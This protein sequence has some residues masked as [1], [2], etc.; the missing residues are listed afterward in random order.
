[1]PCKHKTIFNT[2]ARIIIGQ[3]T[4]G[5]VEKASDSRREEDG[6]LLNA[7]LRRSNEEDEV[8]STSPL[9]SRAEVSLKS[10]EKLSIP[11]AIAP[12]ISGYHDRPYQII[13]AEEFVQSLRSQIKD[14]KISSLPL[15]GAVDQI[16]NNSQLLCQIQT[17]HRL[18]Q[19]ITIP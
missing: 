10:E 3:M 17:C 7:L 12:R 13:N 19:A 14:P 15:F 18:I 5:P 9:I 4:L 16:S 1:M 8:F 6:V 2:R 11:G